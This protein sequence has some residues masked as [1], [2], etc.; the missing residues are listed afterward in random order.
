VASDSETWK[1]LGRDPLLARNEPP[2][3]FAAGDDLLSEGSTART[4]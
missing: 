1:A 3:V 2:G 4:G